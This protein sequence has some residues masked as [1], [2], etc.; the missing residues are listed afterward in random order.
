MPKPAKYNSLIE[1]YINKN[2]NNIIS[3]QQIVDAV[4]CTAPTAYAYIKNNSDRFEKLSAGKYK[5]LAATSFNQL[6]ADS[7]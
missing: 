5:V 4:N 6:S 2:I 7:E 1:V 3:A